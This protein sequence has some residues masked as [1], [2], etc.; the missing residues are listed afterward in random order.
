MRHSVV[1][2]RRQ[3]RQKQKQ[4]QRT[5]LIFAAVLVIAGIGTLIWMGIKTVSDSKY[6]VESP[7]L[8]QEGNQALD[9]ELASLDGGNVALSDYQGNIIIMNMWATWCPPCRAEMPEL[10]QFYQAHKADGLVV[11]AVNGR[12]SESTVRPFI[13]ANNFTFPVLLDIDGEVGRQ[14]MARSFP[15]TYVIDRNGRIH[16]V[17]VGQISEQELEQIVSP[18]IQ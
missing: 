3:A 9:F 1:H 4:K 5:I 2:N 10:D 13:E 11:L 17:K 18:L 16:H 8:M 14:Y 12:E 6:N 7:A 15:T